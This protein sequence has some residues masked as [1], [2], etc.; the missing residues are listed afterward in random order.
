MTGYV[1]VEVDVKFRT[2]V[3]PDDYLTD[4]ED[5]VSDETLAFRVQNELKRR[6]GILYDEM[7]TCSSYEIN[8]E[9]VDE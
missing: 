7:S 4:T 1:E 9:V 2:F 8:V 3:N 5:E 6:K